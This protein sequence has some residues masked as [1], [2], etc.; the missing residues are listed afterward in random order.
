MKELTQTS[1]EGFILAL[2]AAGYAITP[3]KGK[4]AYIDNWQNTKFDSLIDP[5]E[6]PDNYG[7]VLGPEDLVIDADPRSYDAGDNP[8]K[9][10]QADIK[11]SLK[12]TFVVK[13]GN[14]GYHVYLKKPIDFHVR[15]SVPKYKGLEFFSYGHQ[16]VGPGSTHPDTG[17]KYARACGDCANVISAPENLL[18]IV[19]K[20]EVETVANGLEEY[21]DDEQ[22]CLRAGS[23]LINNAPVAREGELGDVT[24]FKV[25]CRLR[26]FGL[27]PDKTLQLMFDSW[28]SKCMPPWSHEELEQKIRNAYTY[29]QVA[30]GTNHPQADFESLV[31]EGEEQEASIVWDVTEAGQIKK[32]L[33]NTVNYFTH[34]SFGL[35]DMFTYNEFTSDVSFIRNAPWHLHTPVNPMWTEQDAISAKLYL[36]RKHRYEPSVNLIHETVVATSRTKSYHPVKEYL[37]GL[38]WD[39][40]ERLKSWLVDYAGVKNNEYVQAIGIKTLVA[41]VSR[42]YKPGCK[43][44]YVLVLEGEQGIG[45]STLINILGGDWYGD[46]NL[47]TH[48]KDTVD[49]MRGKWV[50]EVSEMEC[51]RR[52]ETQALKAFITRQV[53]RVRLAYARQSTDFPRQCIFIGTTNPEA[54]NGYLKDTTGNRRFWPVYCTKVDFDG[55]YAVRDQLWAEAIAKFKAGEKLFIN[56]RDVNALAIQE[57]NRRVSDDPWTDQVAAFLDRPDMDGIKPDY[58]TGLEVYESAIGGLAKNFTR[59]E[60]VRIAN[61]MQ[62]LRWE[63]GTFYHNTIGRVVNC[64]KRPGALRTRS[65]KYFSNK[66]R[67]IEEDLGEI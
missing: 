3:L 36:S 42:I 13:T 63:R 52:Q 29:N 56:N 62:K 60:A 50:I 7:V 28:N 57:A 14:A 19:K 58:V 61:C 59:K 32:T 23:Y 22:T 49:A 40:T 4:R 20:T 54:E 37:D 47:D 33:N 34:S 64:Y 18:E 1:K 21:K 39:G 12:S 27:S 2:A 31:E 9:R 26:D 44:D 8:L 45:K 43:F 55:L 53:D 15:K 48:S 30:P 67:K 41:A 11:L 6:F 35:S 65:R 25:A 16:V 46:I 17:K 66:V 51:T 5:K 10:L 24:T 38:E